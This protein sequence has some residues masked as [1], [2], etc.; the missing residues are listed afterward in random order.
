MIVYSTTKRGFLKDA[1]N[2]IEDK[3]R[4]CVKEKLNIDVKPGSS[5]Y[6]SWKNSLGNAMYHAMNTDTI[7]DDAGVAIEY[8]IPRTKNRI[9]FLV[10]G[11][12]ENG[13]EKVVIIELKQWTEIVATEKDA[14]VTTRF[15]D[16]VRDVLHPSYQAWSYCTLLNGFNATVYEE[17]IE[18]EPCAYLHNCIHEEA[19][20][21]PF[22]VDYLTKAPAFC[23][24]DKEKLQNFISKFIKHGEKKNTIYR[25]DNGE[26]RPS[27]DLAESLASMIKG[28][29]EFVMIDDQKIAYENAL[30][31]A[32]KSRVD[33][34]NV[35]IVEGGPGTGK[36]VV[37]INLLVAITKLDLNAQYITK[38]SAPRAVFEAKLTGT[39]KKTQISNMFSGSGSY[40]DCEPNI[41]DALIIDEAHRL[42]GRSGMFKN[43]GENQIK[44]IIKASKCSI[45]FIDEDQKVTWHDI[46]TKEEIEEWAKKSDAV[47]YHL[48]LES[49]FRCNGSDGYLSW[50][51]SI[52]QIEETANKTLDDINYD[53]KVVSSP[54]ELRDIIFEKN[55]INNKARL[56]A[57]YCWNWMS[58]KNK[59]LKDITIPE[60]NFEMKWNLA[61]DGNLWIISPNSVNEVGCIHTCQGLEMDYVGVIIGP[62]LIVRNG[63]IITDPSKRA[64]TDASIRGYQKEFKENPEMAMQKA[65]A[66]IKNTYRTLMTRGMKGC[67]IYSTDKETEEYFRNSLSTLIMVKQGTQVAKQ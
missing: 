55:K 47:V 37:A 19:I 61:S 8:S 29:S 5:E 50:L 51:D 60:F 40:I 31:L 52:L 64:K 53:F 13:Q 17:K 6:E 25:I 45:F 62:D 9:D 42:N 20:K 18:L 36:S 35:L 30:A 3:V 67:Y 56:V 28:N 49:Q 27:R 22:Y 41:F 59:D 24:S 12:D 34:K 54:N 63:R 1:E 38:N 21:D 65:D 2:N 26:I 58:K 11:E 33:N 66:I 15:K 16:G 14:M 10:T 48:K 46:G 7:P 57:G 4:L 32:R 44:E 43:L 39:L 23:K